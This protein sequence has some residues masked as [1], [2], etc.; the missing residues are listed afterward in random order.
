VH[1]L[2]ASVREGERVSRAKPRRAREQKS[3]L[4]GLLRDVVADLLEPIDR[5][6]DLVYGDELETVGDL[7]SAKVTCQLYP[8]REVR[9]REPSDSLE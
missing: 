9:E 6:F 2:V 5:V 8:A 7:S 3:V 1:L 4:V